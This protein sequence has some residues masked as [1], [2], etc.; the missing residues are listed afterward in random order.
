MRRRRPCII[1]LLEQMIEM[2]QAKFSTYC[3]LFLA[4]VCLKKG[5]EGRTSSR[6]HE[7]TYGIICHAAR[8]EPV[9][10]MAHK[11]RVQTNM[12]NPCLTADR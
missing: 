6:T 11:L 4:S 7:A 5:L 8:A 12:L 3:L 1:Y 9:R 10:A 2:Q